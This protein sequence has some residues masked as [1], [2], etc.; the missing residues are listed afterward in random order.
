MSLNNNWLNRKEGQMINVT[1]PYSGQSID[2]TED[3]HKV[4][5]QVKQDEIDEKYDA[6][7]KGLSKFSKMNAKAYFVLLD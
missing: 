1:N 7:Q 5:M 4:Y 6:M 3:E 2:L